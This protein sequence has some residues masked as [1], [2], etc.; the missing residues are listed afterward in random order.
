MKE[1]E[2]KQVYIK[3]ITDRL[4]SCDME[5]IERIYELIIYRV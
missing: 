1:S 4:N 3:K 5:L 2:R